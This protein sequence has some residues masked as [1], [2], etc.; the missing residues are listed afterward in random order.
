MCVFPCMPLSA[1]APSNISQPSSGQLFAATVAGTQKHLG[2]STKNL[3]KLLTQHYFFVITPPP[4]YPAAFTL[5]PSSSFI[6]EA[7]SECLT[8]FRF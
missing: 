2:K 1:G 4:S 6:S 5:T 8:N 7:S 3:S